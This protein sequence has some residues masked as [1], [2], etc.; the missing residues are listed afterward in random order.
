MDKEG[1]LKDIIVLNSESKQVKHFQ[2]NYEMHRDRRYLLQVNEIAS[3]RSIVYSYKLHYND[4]GG[5]ARPG[6]RSYDFWGYN[7]SDYLGDYVSL[8]PNMKVYTKRWESN[9]NYSKC[10]Y[11]SVILGGDP[12][13][14]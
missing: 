14:F 4:T 3:D 8:V 1:Y 5:V 12:N 13:R 10:E 7:N 6:G 9:G 2:L 11:D